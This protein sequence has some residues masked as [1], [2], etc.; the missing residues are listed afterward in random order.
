MKF[1]TYIENIVKNHQKIFHKDQCMYLRMRTRDINVH[2]R[3]FCR[4]E[5]CACT[6]MPRVRP[7]VHG[8]FDNLLIILYY[9][10][11]I[12]LKFH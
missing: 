12:N 9:L 1:E 10:I 5:T 3:A 4:D 7:S 11:N 2:A 8:S 6:F